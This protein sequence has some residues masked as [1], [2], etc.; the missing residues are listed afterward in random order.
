MV[1]VDRRL[2]SEL[3]HRPPC[4]TMK[5]FFKHFIDFFIWFGKTI[6]PN[7]SYKKI[8]I[9]NASVQAKSFAGPPNYSWVR[10]SYI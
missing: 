1:V 5:V 7:T 6:V 10:N 4:G 2:S 9:I 8:N 3:S